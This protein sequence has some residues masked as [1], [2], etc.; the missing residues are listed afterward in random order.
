MQEDSSSR[1]CP[2]PVASIT[3]RGPDDDGHLS[4]STTTGPQ[5]VGRV[6]AFYGNTGM[7]IR[8][9]AYILANGPDGLRQ[10]TE[11]AVLNANYIRKNLE[12]LMNCPTRLRRCTK[13]FSATSGRLP[14][15]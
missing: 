11:D 6:R 3:R 14:R 5:S 1:F 10:T 15:E 13:S 4:A 7:F 8:A 2:R 12:D 9:L